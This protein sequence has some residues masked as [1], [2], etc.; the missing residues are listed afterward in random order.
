[1]FNGIHDLL[2]EK[3]QVNLE[4]DFY[5]LCRKFYWKSLKRGVANRRA[6]KVAHSILLLKGGGSKTVYRTSI[7]GSMS[8]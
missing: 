8:K 2:P 5:L 4:T 7:T 6:P 1:M 3:G